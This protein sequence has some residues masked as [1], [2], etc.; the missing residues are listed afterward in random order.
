MLIE[1]N[2]TNPFD[3]LVSLTNIEKFEQDIGKIIQG[4]LPYYKSILKEMYSVNQQNA[5]LLY[6]FLLKE[7][8][9][10]NVKQG[11][12]ITYIKIIFHFNKFLSF[13]DFD[14]TT[15][16]DI[17]NYLNSLRKSEVGDPTHKW[18]GTHNTRQM[19][20]NKFFRWM[21]NKH[22][23]NKEKW[24]SPE[25]LLGIKS[26]RR[27]EK[28]PY[29]PSDIW[30]NEEH[31]IFLKYCPEKRDQC[32]HAMANDTSC[33][34]HELLSLKIGDIKFKMSSKGT[35]YAEV[36]IT[37]SKTRP[38][39]LPLIFS[40]PYVKEWI[41]LHPL[42]SNPNSWLFISLSDTTFGKQLTENGLYKQYARKYK[43][44]FFPSLLNDPSIEERDKACEIY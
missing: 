20:L 36:H 25:C 15:N 26:L 7:H 5:N 21:Y 12:K 24:I 3:N 22:E 38:R 30:T 35:Q 42:G 10:R 44:K 6:S 18:I 39:T 32:Y 28:S 43:L 1:T 16:H 2:R 40:I 37:D 14:K 23:Y 27:K 33:R 4:A 11:T 17:I 8:T 31:S 9:E 19:I 13:K 29:K 34:P 41:E